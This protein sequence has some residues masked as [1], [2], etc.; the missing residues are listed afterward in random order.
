M[1][2][3]TCAFLWVISDSPRLSPRAR[4]VF[5]ATGNE[6]F[7]SPV[8]SWEIALKFRKGQI[9]L[10][11]QAETYLPRQRRKHLISSLPIQEIDALIAAGLPRIHA[12]PF[13]RLLIGQ[14]LAN[15]LTI[16]TP[17]R[18]IAAYDVS[19]LW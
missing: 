7:V 6:I 17:D 19:T 9:D 11:E 2:L 15:G 10:P 18:H 3:D 1:L 14:A 12:D 5:G 4:E 16:L 13:D 8:S